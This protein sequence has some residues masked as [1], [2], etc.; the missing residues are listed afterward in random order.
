V[1]TPFVL[2]AKFS[3]IEPSAIVSV[4]GTEATP[5]ELLESET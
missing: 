2:I 5:A 1:A 4:P 3:L